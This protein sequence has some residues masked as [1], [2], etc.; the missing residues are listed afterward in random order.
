L[1]LGPALNAYAECK[2]DLDPVRFTLARIADDICYGAG[3]W[4]GCLRERT[5][6]PVRP[7]IA[8][9]PLRLSGCRGNG[10]D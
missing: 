7:V 5:L 10:K 9:R 2:P 8:W 1:L 3:V 4:S 6:V